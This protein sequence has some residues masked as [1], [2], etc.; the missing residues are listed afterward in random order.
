MHLL[1]SNIAK[2]DEADAAIDLEQS[3]AEIVVLSFADSDLSALAAAWK[4]DAAILPTLRLASLKK[5]KHPMS[6]DLYA[7]RV[8]AKAR[9]VIV[10]CLGGFE[11]WRYGLEIITSIARQKNILFAALPGDDRPDPRL[12]EISTVTA[13]TLSRL[14]GFFREGGSENLCQALRYVG[15]LLDRDISWTDAM[16]IGPVAGFSTEGRAVL[17]QDLISAVDQRPVAL[18]LFYKASLLAADTA[19]I[20]AL[21]AALEGQDLAPVAVAVTSLKDRAAAESIGQLIAARRPAIILN[22]TAF[23]ALRDDGTTV[24]DAADVPV[25]QVVLA[26]NAQEAWASSSRGLS[27]ADLAMNVVLPELDGRLLSRAV[28][29]KAEDDFD[30]RIEFAAVRH[31]PCPDRIDFVARQAGAFV[32]LSRT[33]RAERKLALVLSDYPARAGRAGYAVGLDT[34]ESVVQIVN[35]L[36]A[37]GYDVGAEELRAADVE[38]LLAG[39]SARLDIPLNNYA[40][41]LKALPPTLQNE[42]ENIWG[43]PAADPSA[44]NDA[45]SFPVLKAGKLLVFL[46]PDRGSARDRKAGYHDTSIP[47]RHAYVALYAWLREQAQIDALIHL[48]THGTLEWLPGKAL[49]P[50]AESWPEA[51]TGP[52]PVIY[53]FIVNNPGEAVQAKRRLSAVTIGH[54]T[55]P[56]SAAG[57]H[58]AMAELEALVE[59]Y[60]DA[61]GLDRRRL[62]LLESAIID[63]AWTTGLAAEC[64]LSKDEP[65]R[66]AIVKLDA[67]LCDIKELSIRD[68]LH[69]FGRAPERDAQS[70]LVE[71]ILAA[72]GTSVTGERREQIEAAVRNSAINEQHALL[73]ALDGRRVSPGPAGAPSR[74]RAD[75]LPTGRNLTTIDPRS[76]PTRTATTIG[77]RAADEVVRRYLQDHGEY[78]RALVIDLWAS[79]SLRTGGDDLAQALGYLGA[80]PVWDMS[81]NRVTGVE[82]LPLAKLERPRIDVTLRISGLFRDIFET[83]IALLDTAIRKIAALDEDDADNPIAGAGRRGD[84]LA[85]IFGS[86]PGSYG[87]GT[88]DLTLDGNWRARED[89]GEAYLSAVTHAYGGA[90]PVMP[91]GDG[92][93]DRVSMADA[94]VH[95]QDDRERDLLDGD[96]VAD[97]VGGFAAAAAALGNDVALY[98]LDTSEPSMPKARTVG[99]EI[100]RIVRGRLTN[101]RWIAGMLGHGHRGVAEIAQ[102]VDALFAFAATTRVVPG[103]LF[104][105]THEALIANEAV[106]AKM[107]AANPA[108]AAAIASRLRDALARGFWVA[109]RNAVAGELDR[110]VATSR[111]DRNPSMEAAQ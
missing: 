39:H 31:K 32:K 34:A 83:Q 47:P 48:G 27:P 57:L 73:A 95:P 59:E 54:L 62:G 86:A 61:E 2:L 79:T 12:S 65:A 18:V 85:R 42:I 106:L 51:V 93:R 82:V 111:H 5:L 67:H 76:I 33:P 108:A 20:R 66:E 105:V 53:P 10:R 63:T 50:S 60:A 36:R 103:H 74:G 24:L 75:V 38:R 41:W 87:A 29:F 101:P 77:L 46:Q 4:S 109:R 100:A 96:G 91:A 55:P 88:A 90:Q 43:D 21:M 104:D 68:R 99:E 49:A 81:S 69:V 13:E 26:S 7:E 37:G 9:A 58:G 8:V 3:P 28:S 6:V 19:P 84:N 44:E 35:L 92:F 71:A 23:S 45:F 16:P 102:G 107:I 40:T 80:R 15:S 110:A 25:L 52:L 98:H 72:A 14:D 64:N 94:L 1:A 70:T 17:L 56:L 11:Y 89:L 22:A 30:S 78:P 97:F